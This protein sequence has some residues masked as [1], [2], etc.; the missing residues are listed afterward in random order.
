VRDVLDVELE[1]H[2]LLAEILLLIN[3][4]VIASE[5]TQP[6]SQ[7]VIDACLRTTVPG[8]AERAA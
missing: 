8:R 4:M 1:D 2:E 3:L 7:A 5:A 6:L